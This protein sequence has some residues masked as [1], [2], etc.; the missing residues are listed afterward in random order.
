MMRL[1]WVYWSHWPVVDPRNAPERAARRTSRPVLNGSMSVMVD[2]ECYQDEL[3][4]LMHRTTSL[5]RLWAAHTWRIE[6]LLATSGPQRMEGG[7]R[8]NFPGNRTG[9]LLRYSC[10]ISPPCS[11]PVRP[12]L[13]TDQAYAEAVLDRYSE[14]LR[15]L[16]ARGQCTGCHTGL[17]NL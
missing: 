12:R 11:D 8:G 6:P 14:L 4:H 3:D 15:P 17:E 5:C 9:D 2:I 13:K 16:V 7:P 1:A 10:T